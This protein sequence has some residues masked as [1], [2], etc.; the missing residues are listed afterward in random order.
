MNENISG[1]PIFA[2]RYR[3]QPVN[4][5]WDV[6]RS[7]LTH[8]VFDMKKERLGVIKRAELKSPR[9]V[10]GLKNEVAA[11]LDLKGKGVPEIY[12]TGEAEYGSKTYFYM[13]ME[14]I[15]GIRVE[16]NLDS[17]SGADRSE[18][19]M[20]FFKLLANSHKM[21]I[22]NGDVDIKHLFW[23]KDRKKLTVIDWGN[24][25]LDIDKKK[26][27]EFAYD[28]ARSAEIIYLLV[29]P[30]GSHP[31]SNSFTLPKKEKDL[32]PGIITIP[33]EFRELCNWGSLTLAK[34]KVAPYTAEDLFKSLTR[35]QNNRESNELSYGTKWRTLTTFGIILIS[36][37]VFLTMFDGVNV[38]KN[39]LSNTFPAATKVPISLSSEVPVPKETSTPTITLI[40]PLHDTATPTE[41]LTPTVAQTTI[42]PTAT[43]TPFVTPKPQA[44]HQIILLF[45]ESNGPSNDCWSDTPQDA[46]S[47]FGRRSDG[48]WRFVIEEGKSK[49]IA[50]QTSFNGCL[51]VN[52]INAFALNIWFPQV[53]IESDIKPGTEFGFFIVNKDNE[54]REYT[55]WVDK[56]A[57]MHL[58]VRENGMIILDEKIAV[59][60]DRNLK[61]LPNT[62]PR[63]IA[64]YPI[65][66]FF[67]LNNQGMDLLYL[68]QGPI[69]QAVEP[70]ELIP[71]N[72]LIPS[73]NAILPTL[74]ELRDIG[75]I[76]Y[77]GEIQTVIWPLLFYGD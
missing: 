38:I 18:I 74:G 58:A 30:N 67:E 3:F 26:K 51:E 35:K 11:L 73:N 2:D 46:K 32:F 72:M 5:D 53:D 70:N 68:A 63:Q 77:G 33:K 8:L 22:V 61:L 50:I 45:N 44:H 76:G 19:L 69:Q 64:S 20:H 17:L 60:D 52:Q 21:G 65:Q 7:G 25:K 29:M 34:G 42:T 41:T 59:V 47:G 40:T 27:T 54:I 10:E 49:D 66:F 57:T 37:I 39:I 6:G 23:N 12:D 24:A 1:S 9:A 4:A 71:E 16:K 62:Y 36:T 56:T 55:I 31:L 75:L 48:N 15:E 28:L 13:V 43:I 14:Y